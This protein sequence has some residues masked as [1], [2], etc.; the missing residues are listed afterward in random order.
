MAYTGEFALQVEGYSDGVRRKWAD[1]K[2][3]TVESLLD[4]I[5]IGIEALLAARKAAREEREER[6]RVWEELSRRRDLAR[7]R[8]EREGKRL[9]YIRSVMDLGDEA[10]RLRR[11]LDRPEVKTG[12][13][14]TD[15]ASLVAW[16]KQRV[17]N[18]EA[19]L[20]PSHIDDDLKAKKLFPE[21]DDLAD[22]LGEPPSEPR[23]W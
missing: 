20:D 10:D 1:G 16:V 9:T 19:T 11:W 2:T 23:Y 21:V 4:D 12:G 3:Q 7:Q 17:S 18:L 6:Q 22:P 13:A 5:V 14:G 15:Y 8:N